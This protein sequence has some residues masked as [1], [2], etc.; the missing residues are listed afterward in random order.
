MASFIV[1]CP[2]TEKPIET[3]IETEP[4]SLS[5]V[6]NVVVHVDCPHCGSAHQIQVKEGRLAESE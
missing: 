2:K 4:A 1:Y 3:G 6:D 5:R